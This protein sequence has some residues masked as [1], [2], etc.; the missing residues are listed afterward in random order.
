MDNGPILYM[1]FIDFPTFTW[2][3]SVAN[4]VRYAGGILG[5]TRFN[6]KR[7]P[8]P[9]TDL[10]TWW[11]RCCHRSQLPGQRQ[12]CLPSCHR[13]A[14][15]DRGL[16]KWTFFVISWW[17]NS[18]W[19]DFTSALG[20]LRNHQWGFQPSHLVSNHP[21]WWLTGKSMIEYYV[22]LATWT[23]T[24]AGDSPNAFDHAL[25]HIHF[26]RGPWLKLFPCFVLVY[27]PSIGCPPWWRSIV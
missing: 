24:R 9:P 1:N 15:G 11:F 2:W 25:V 8:V 12:R 17:F 10:G 13:C 20:F 21:S 19:V 3:F 7:S 4:L 5:D 22:L 26:K 18:F 23:G 14:P 27:L 16:G 6:M